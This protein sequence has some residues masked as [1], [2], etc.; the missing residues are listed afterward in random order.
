MGGKKKAKGNAEKPI[1]NVPA[2]SSIKNERSKEKEEEMQKIMNAISSMDLDKKEFIDTASFDQSKNILENA[3]DD[4][5][6]YIAL[7]EKGEYEKFPKYK[8]AEA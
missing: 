5:H 4:L 6:H 1:I 8:P 3:L 2:N 7:F